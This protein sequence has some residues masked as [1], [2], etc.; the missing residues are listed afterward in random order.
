M[1]PADHNDE[2][3]VRIQKLHTLRALG[4]NPYPDKFDKKQDISTLCS[5]GEGGTFRTIEEII[6]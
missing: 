5:Q 1:P 6:L 3:S 2:R 4:I